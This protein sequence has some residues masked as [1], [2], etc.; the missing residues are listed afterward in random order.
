M[1][2]HISA[3]KNSVSNDEM[4][5]T[6]PEFYRKRHVAYFK[7]NYGVLPH[8]LK[9]LD[10]SR[11]MLLY[12]ALSGLDVLGAVELLPED[13]RR[14]M[15]DWI[16]S[17]QVVDIDAG[18]GRGRSRRGGF[19]GC[20]SFA[21]AGHD[22]DAGHITMTYTA[23]CSL[24]ILGNDL[25][26]VNRRSVLEGVKALQLPDGS[27]MN[28][29][30]G[31][32]NDLR[33]MYCACAVASLL[34]DRSCIDREKAIEFILSCVNYDGG[35][36]TRPGGESHG[37]AVYCGVASLHLLGAELEPS[38]KEALQMW[39]MARTFS[40]GTGGFQGRPNKDFVDEFGGQQNYQLKKVDP[41]LNVSVD[42]LKRVLEL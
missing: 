38:L 12:F 34:R 21:P 19:R 33:F 2:E 15:I 40:E 32:E 30:N 7:F 25:D 14:Q 5:T 17:L 26:R 24:L 11:C 23:L 6:T 9:D 8:R 41:A 42:A 3:E 29:L 39:C 27:F 4:A 37:G 22:Y 31:G 35:M 20:P 1:M 13:D 36:G 18:D 16:Y 28:T 10:V